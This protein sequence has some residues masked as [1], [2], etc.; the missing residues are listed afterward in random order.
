MLLTSGGR[1]GDSDEDN[2]SDSNDD[3]TSFEAMAEVIPDA[4][5][6]FC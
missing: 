2:I 6:F 1:L 4:V 5:N 3:A